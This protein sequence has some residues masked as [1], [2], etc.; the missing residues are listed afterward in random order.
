MHG[1]ELWKTD[2]TTAGTVLVNDMNPGSGAATPGNLINLNGTLFFTVD[3]IETLNGR[4]APERSGC[5]L[6]GGEPLPVVQT[7]SQA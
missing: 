4:A 6:R 7:R 3:W 2:G 5:A 1:V